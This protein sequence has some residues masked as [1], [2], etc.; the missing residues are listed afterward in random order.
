M[1]KHATFIILTAI[2]VILLL[3]FGVSGTG[4]GGGNGGNQG[5]EK[6]YSGNG[7]GQCPAGE[8]WNC[9][10]SEGYTDGTSSQCKIPAGEEYV[11][12][13]RWCYC[14]GKTPNCGNC[15]YSD[16]AGAGDRNWSFKT[17]VIDTSGNSGNSGTST[18]ISDN[19]YRINSNDYLCRQGNTYECCG[20]SA[21][22]C[23]SDASG[24]GQRVTTG[25]KTTIGTNQYICQ[26]DRTW[27]SSA[28]EFGIPDYGWRLSPD[29]PI[30]EIMDVVGGKISSCRATYSETKELKATESYCTLG[31]TLD[32]LH[33]DDDG[34]VK[35]GGQTVG[36]DEGCCCKENKDASDLTDCGVCDSYGDVVSTCRT[37]TLFDLNPIP[38]ELITPGEKTQV[39]ISAYDKCGS[40]YSCSPVQFRIFKTDDGDYNSEC[41]GELEYEWTGSKCCGESGK[42]YNNDSTK[43]CWDGNVTLSGEF[44]REKKDV[45][46][47][48]GQFYGCKIDGNNYIKDNKDILNLKDYYTKKQ[49]VVNKDY[50]EVV[51]EDTL[52]CSYTEE[53][54]QGA[55]QGMHL[56]KIPWTTK[57]QKGE[58]CGEGKCFNGS[59]CLDNQADKPSNEPLYEGYRCV[60]G[61]WHKA[62]KACTPDGDTCGYCP[63]KSQ[64]L[65]DLQGDVTDNDDPEGT[66]QCIA[67][68][69]YINDDYCENGKWSS[70]TKWVA[71]QMLDIFANNYALFCGDY[72]EVLNYLDYIVKDATIARNYAS[73]TNNYCVLSFGDKVVFGTSINNETKTKFEDIVGESCKKVTNEDGLYHPCTGSNRAWYNKKLKSVIYSQN[74]LKLSDATGK[75]DT[76]LGSPFKSLINKLSAKFLNPY[77]DFFKGATSRFRSLYVVKQ[78]KKYVLG[79]IE[80]KFYRNLAIEYMDFDTDVC[81]LMGA[82]NQSHS[83]FMSGIFCSKENKN[84]YVLAQ[85]SIFAALDPT[86]IWA[87][88]T[89]KLRVES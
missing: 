64:C 9:G 43:G 52:Y 75:F 73:Q 65:V 11:S 20:D 27:T 31:A 66:P 45:I 49:L 84:Y 19:I 81:K 60:N 5:S 62:Q 1:K 15:T 68:G 40:A 10:V 83:D 23:Q 47:Y 86:T 87:D 32:I 69:Q 18:K 7:C 63:K 67:N 88:V 80:G 24:A 48:H 74:P 50:C 71:V 39:E 22:N 14:H 29:S 58:C 85:G 77:D 57:L 38:D 46:S 16:A 13:E 6:T 30:K 28:V 55:E 35:I 3:A 51:A 12:G 72:E 53:W 76:Y 25:F 54:K 37:P 42:Y 82:Y 21:D 79:S 61:E 78:D 56:S 17:K 41:C 33:C 59:E 4:G 8:E 26:S 70:R 2:S 34:E 36:K 44:P 89:G